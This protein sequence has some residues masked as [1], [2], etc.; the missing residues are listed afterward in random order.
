MFGIKFLDEQIKDINKKVILVEGASGIGKE[1]IGYHYIFNGIKKGDLPVFVFS[2]REISD[3]EEEFSD[4]GMKIDRSFIIW[5]NAG[6][7][8]LREKNVINCNISELFTISS[9]IK[10]VLSENKKRNIRIFFPIVSQAILNN[11]S[12]EF[13]KFFSSIINEMKKY[14]S[15]ILAV[16]EDGMHD[17]QTV[18]AIEN[19]C[20]IVFDIKVY[21]R[22]FEIVPL[23]RIKKARGKPLMLKYFRYLVNEKGVSIGEE[24]VG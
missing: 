5:I 2:G 8:I 9:A 11:S 20:D 22:N 7:E 17:P 12:T 24:Y 6:P 13:Y 15:S 4:Y 14:N 1:I 10:K 19:L 3:I 18:V 23:F 16:I 21:E